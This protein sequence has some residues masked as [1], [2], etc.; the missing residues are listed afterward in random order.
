MEFVALTEEEQAAIVQGHLKQ[1]EYDYFN[2]YITAE[3]VKATVAAREAEA[4]AA[5]D[6]DSQNLLNQ[7]VNQARA[8][9]VEYD[10]AV[11]RAERD[12]EV[13]KGLI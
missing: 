10:A 11:A 3:K 4:E 8:Q 6:P 12:I 7:L 5:Q 9:Q 13:V 1:A 2:A